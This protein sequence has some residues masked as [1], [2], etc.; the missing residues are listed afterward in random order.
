M[1]TT[2]IYAYNCPCYA[3]KGAILANFT[4]KTYDDLSS[5]IEWGVVPSLSENNCS[6]Y[7]FSEIYNKC[8]RMKRTK[9]HGHKKFIS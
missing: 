9:M 4:V 6:S 3:Q 2:N 8:F 1:I 5:H 7:I